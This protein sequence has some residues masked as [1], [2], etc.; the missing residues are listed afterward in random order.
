MK[1]FK[2]CAL[3][4]PELPKVKSYRSLGN[5]TEAL[6]LYCSFRNCFLSF[7]F[8]SCFES[9]FKQITFHFFNFEYEDILL[10]GFYFKDIGISSH[11]ELQFFT[12]IVLVTNHV[13]AA[14][15]RELNISRSTPNRSIS[16]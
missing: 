16:P 4:M 12:K 15:E 8:T 6:Y 11:K 3:G 2:A 5:P 9:E 14:V 13:Q 10:S 1:A 7:L